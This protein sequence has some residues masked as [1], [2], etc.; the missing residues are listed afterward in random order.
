MSGALMRRCTDIVVGLDWGSTSVRLVICFLPSD[1]EAIVPKPE[2]LFNQR[3]LQT[4]DGTRYEKGA[5]NGYINISGTGEVYTGDE[6]SPSATQVSAKFFLG[7]GF[8]DTGRNTIN[9]ENSLRVEALR[10]KDKHSDFETIGKKG[11][12]LILD[13]V[14]LRLDE[15]CRKME[16]PLRIVDFG[17]SAPAH[18]SVTE[19]EKYKA[20]IREKLGSSPRLLTSRSFDL[21]QIYDHLHLHTEAEA[22][23]HFISSSEHIA[24][25]RLGTDASQYVLFLDF[26]GHSM[27]GCL[28]YVRRAG[29]KTAL[30]RA[31]DPIATVGGG[32]MW[33][34]SVGDF[35]TNHTTSDNGKV[36][37]QEFSYLL[38]NEFL[39]EFRTRLI[40]LGNNNPFKEE[41][42]N[43]FKSQFEDIDLTIAKPAKYFSTSKRFHVNIPIHDLTKMFKKA[44]LQ[45]LLEAERGIRNLEA[46]LASSQ[47]DIR[48]RIVVSG[49]GAKNQRVKYYLF[50][51]VET[52]F[53]NTVSPPIVYL[54][55]NPETP[56][57]S[58]NTA[59]GAGLATAKAH[60]TIQNYIKNG[61]AFGIQVQRGRGGGGDEEWDDF[62]AMILANNRKG[63]KE[64]RYHT[65]QTDGTNRFRIVCDPFGLHQSMSQTDTQ[66]LRYLDCGA[67]TYDFLDLFMPSQGQWQFRLSVP[68]N[69]SSEHEHLV[70][71]RLMVDRGRELWT[72]YDKIKLDVFFSRSTST[73]LVRP[74]RKLDNLHL[75]L[76][77]TPD[78]IFVACTAETEKTWFDE[79][80]RRTDAIWAEKTREPP[81]YETTGAKLVEF[82]S[83]SE[84]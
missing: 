30:F 63:M 84:A 35:C 39:R 10:I 50:K 37:S 17:L 82:S 58:F 1:G 8:L 71:E 78:G 22:M 79:V 21:D 34:A 48:G 67:H 46:E 2:E 74:D 73:F 68:E 55:Q 26:G 13:A 28:Y 4:Q 14:F 53:Q 7:D 77:L 9:D 60:Q 64:S 80:Q 59:K 49:G 27:N 23:A 69:Q 12:G 47:K 43:E 70:L 40:A 83:D 54:D 61:A 20:L 65:F 5:F 44:F 3:S 45:P 19:Y 75:G 76:G 81:N 32:G 52:V 51:F 31:G 16:R 56:N 15:E 36:S 11:L 29:G 33:E 38:R 62:A 24:D 57:E 25:R 42:P 66:S 18:W 72:T 6:L 41:S